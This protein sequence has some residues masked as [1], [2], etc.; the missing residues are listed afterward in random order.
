[1]TRWMSRS[2]Q[3][4]PQ[5]S[6]PAYKRIRRCQ[7]LCRYAFILNSH[8]SSH[9]PC[10]SQPPAVGQRG[11]GSDKLVVMTA[12]RA[13]MSRRRRAIG[14]SQEE[15]ALRVGVDVRTLRRWEV[16][17]SDPQP[18][19]RPALAAELS[20]T[21]AELDE[22]L[23]PAEGGVPLDRGDRESV[24]GGTALL[25]GLSKPTSTYIR[26]HGVA[27]SS[28]ILEADRL[29]WRT[30]RQVL[31]KHRSELSAAAER[32]YGFETVVPRVLTRPGWLLERPIPPDRLDLSWLGR[33]PAPRI[34]GSEEESA[35]VRPLSLTGGRYNRYSQAIKA[36]ERPTL[37]ENRLSYRLTSCEWAG[38][39]GHLVFGHTTYF[40]ML[41]TCEAVAHELAAAWKAAGC[42][43]GWLA[44]PTGRDLPLRSAIGDPFDLAARAVLPSID[45]LTLRRAADGSAT[46]FLHERSDAN[47]AVAGSTLHV[48]P[49]GVFQPSTVAPWD[50]ENDF[51]IWRNIM[52][53]YAEEFLDLPE[54]DGSSG[55]ALDYSNT[56]PYRS[57]E[58]ARIAGD[59]RVFCFG[60]V[61]DP[62]TLAAEIITAV[63]IDHHVFDSVF[64]HMVRANSEGAVFMSSRREG[65][66]GIPFDDLTQRNLLAHSSLAPAAAAC[67][68]LAWLHR[69]ALLNW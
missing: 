63:V 7:Q 45:T 66:G 54:A 55:E 59:L 52:R 12:R 21:L 2:R 44:A 57:L 69:D 15:L 11:Q 26:G 25:N 20:T 19:H 13:E 16:G 17:T 22:L 39:N 1:M 30:T 27:D 34:T 33:V 5:G 43:P 58:R 28:P 36:L 3:A 6:Q 40:D 31:N 49:A 46:L 61:L 14:L 32:L 41:D 67:L 47:V 48:M 24:R 42:A 64:A 62:L 51:D 37:F 56:E 29:A 9:S 8:R 23:F 53:E 65:S 38:E 50:L 60:I 10:D 68:H 18:W 35:A 4:L